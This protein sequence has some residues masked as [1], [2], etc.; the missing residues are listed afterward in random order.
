MSIWY[1][2]I[3]FTRCVVCTREGINI[4]CM[5]EIYSLSCRA[6]VRSAPG[7]WASRDARFVPG[8]TFP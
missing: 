7:A 8:C 3:R 6:D 4:M 5:D 2:Y 1:Q